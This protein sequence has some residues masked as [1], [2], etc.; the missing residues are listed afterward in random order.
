MRPLNHR[1]TVIEPLEARRLLSSTSGAI[2]QSFGRHGTGMIALNLPAGQG[3]ILAAAGAQP[4]GKIL[5]AGTL[6]TASGSAF[7]LARFNADGKADTSF[8]SGGVVTTPFADNGAACNSLLVEAD[9]KIVAAGLADGG[10]ALARYN[11]DGSLDATFGNGGEVRTVI[12]GSPPVDIALDAAGRIVAATGSGDDVRVARYNGDGSLDGTFGA[13]GIATAILPGESGQPFGSTSLRG[14]FILGEGRILAVADGS[15]SPGSL[16]TTLAYFNSD[17]SF[18]HAATGPTGTDRFTFSAPDNAV[19]DGSQI[20]TGVG[21]YEASPNPDVF[22]LNA[23]GSTDSSFNPDPASDGFFL[24]EGPPPSLF[25]QA[26]GKI[27]VVGGFGSNA[28]GY[29]SAMLRYNT[30][31]SLDTGFGADGF[32]LSPKGI[33]SEGAALEP[34]GNIVVVG[35]GATDNN[36]L[37]RDIFATRFLGGVGV[38]PPTLSF[39]G[40]GL[41]VRGTSLITIKLAFPAADRID[42]TSLAVLDVNSMREFLPVELSRSTKHPD[43][44]ITAVYDIQ[45]DTQ[46]HEFNFTDN[47]DY[48]VT[49]QPTSLVDIHGVPAAGA[50]IAHLTINIPEPAGGLVQPTATLQAFGV[51]KPKRVLTFNVTYKGSVPIDPNF[52]FLL[53]G[54][55]RGSQMFFDVFRT[56]EKIHADGSLTATYVV[57]KLFDDSGFTSADNGVYTITVPPGSVDDVEGTPVVGGVIGTIHVEIPTQAALQALARKAHA[58]HVLHILHVRRRR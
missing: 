2:D 4:D 38:T 42:L 13:G 18:D 55:T 35:V 19:L 15:A 20:I 36:G 57:G 37:S 39:H 5:A 30:D 29:L 26:G 41:R 7:L 12:E 44:S 34:D 3:V 17:G 47:G 33:L 22:R 45:K 56:S 1:P 9:G 54:V 14:L 23:D 50:V 51:R 49:L 58:A 46:G 8:G 31:G 11:A 6:T 24:G 52:T 25:V 43:G 27:L 10:L 53:P 40:R 32:A 28:R 48:S 16:T 21:L